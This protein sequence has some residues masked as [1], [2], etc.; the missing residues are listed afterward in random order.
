MSDIDNALLDALDSIGE[1]S[2]LDLG[3]LAAPIARIN[4]DDRDFTTIQ[5]LAS[6][7]GCSDSTTRKRVHAL[8]SRGLVDAYRVVQERDGIQR[9]LV[10][11]EAR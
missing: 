11:G 9:I 8:A 3:E 2:L 7:V 6:R 5:R 1:V 4:G 10:T